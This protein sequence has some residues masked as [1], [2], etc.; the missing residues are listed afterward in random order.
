MAVSPM[1]IGQRTVIA[2]GT[3]ICQ[4]TEDVT[5]PVLSISA[6]FSFEDHPNEEARIEFKAQET[7]LSIVVVNV[8]VPPDSPIRETSSSFVETVGK[9]AQQKDIV[10]ALYIQSRG[11]A[12]TRQITYTF[13]A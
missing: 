2:T 8:D 9:T 11:Q 3:V 6:R 4:G 5:I 12:K 7:H 10:M 13:S 1:R